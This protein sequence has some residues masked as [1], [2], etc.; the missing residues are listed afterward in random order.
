MKIEELY[1]AE[2][3]NDYQVKCSNISHQTKIQIINPDLPFEIQAEVLEC[4]EVSADLHCYFFHT[5]VSDFPA[6]IPEISQKKRVNKARKGKQNERV[7]FCRKQ[8]WL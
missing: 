8:K 5:S 7:V 3:N 6:T 1:F 4:L 2:K